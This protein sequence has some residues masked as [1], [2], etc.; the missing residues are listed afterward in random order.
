MTGGGS[1]RRVL[2]LALGFFVISLSGPFAEGAVFY[3]TQKGA[4]LRDGAS[5][6]NAYGEGRFPIVLS[7]ARAGAEFW[8]AKGRYRPDTQGRQ[9]RSFVLPPGA[10]LYGGFVGFENSVEQRNS[11]VHVTV[12]TGDL[13]LDDT[14]NSHG[15]TEKVEDIKRGEQSN[16][17]EMYR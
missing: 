16:G 1:V 4:G 13:D 2:Y 5:W 3:V 8:I 11:E 6:A 15:V 7:E 14:V 17:F 12:F 10:A 9:D